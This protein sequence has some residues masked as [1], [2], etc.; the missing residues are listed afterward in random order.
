MVNTDTRGASINKYSFDQWAG[1]GLGCL[2]CAAQC[3]EFAFHTVYKFDKWGCSRCLLDERN[4]VCCDGN[5][6][7]MYVT[8]THQTLIE[9]A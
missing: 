6:K 8:N 2:G 7:N 5:E 4:S 1:H 3:A 9:N